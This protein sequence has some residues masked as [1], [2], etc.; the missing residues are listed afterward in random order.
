MYNYLKDICYLPGVSG[1]ES[2]VASYIIEQI[3]L[4][5]DGLKRDSLGN[6]IAFK[7]GKKTPDGPIMVA[8]HMDEVGMIVTSVDDA[9]R[10]F[11]DT[12][13]GIDERILPGLRVFVNDLP[14]QISL[15]PVHMCDKNEKSA[16]IETDKLF[17]D[18]GAANRDEL[19]GSVS[20]GD[21]ISFQPFY[22]EFGDNLIIAKALDDRAGCAIMIDL[23][24][25]PLEYDTYF[26]FTVMEEVGLRGARAAA[27]GI[28][29]KKAIVLETTTAV[30]IDGVDEKDVV[31]RLNEGPVISYI[32]KRTIYDR[33]YCCKAFQC[34]RQL[35]IKCQTK[36]KICGGNDAGAIHVSTGGVRTI[37]ISVPCRYLHT[38]LC[39]ASKE[40]IAASARLCR[41][42]IS[43]MGE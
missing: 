11:F 18:V 29:P 39:V 38:P 7:K 37:A 25:Q 22:E 15:K 30:D 26:V 33:E 31:C 23:I 43:F 13:G 24:H 36:T 14:G 17:I 35:G 3:R 10:I 21:R 2:H 8:S 12:V 5:V 4:H 34:A 27:F 6:V 20:L 28:A 16:K 42:C 41:E 32:D 1:C 9:G 19:M 40:D